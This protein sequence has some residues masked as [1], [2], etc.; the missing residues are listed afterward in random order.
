MWTNYWLN[1]PANTWQKQNKMCLSL[2]LAFLL[3]YVL[4]LSLLFLCLLSQSLW[5][6]S[7][8]FI[9]HIILS[10]VHPAITLCPWLW[11]C[12][13]PIK[14]I[15]EIAKI[16][17]SFGSGRSYN[18]SHHIWSIE[19]KSTYH[20]KNL[21]IQPICIEKTTQS[22]EEGFRIVVK[23]GGLQLNPTS[24]HICFMTWWNFINFPLGPISSF[25]NGN[26]S[27][28]HLI[29]LLWKLTR[30]YVIFFATLGW[31]SHMLVIGIVLHRMYAQLI[32]LKFWY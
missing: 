27:S 13:Y 9:T 6:F 28:S 16:Q 8:N 1:E 5:P 31:F 18:F 23:S 30:K 24:P 2:G 15:S 12:S 7:G 29:V 11:C 20:F 19:R 14:W 22:L 26:N 10:V 25:V 4:T 17:I 3:N 32:Q 21:L